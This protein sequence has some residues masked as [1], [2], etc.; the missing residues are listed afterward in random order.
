MAARG[1][2]GAGVV[3]C[4]I[5]C[6]LSPSLKAHISHLRLVH[7]DDDRFSLTCGI[8]ECDKQ[9]TSFSGYNSHVYRVHRS[10]L[11][12]NTI[13]TADQ[14]SHSE[15]NLIQYDDLADDDFSFPNEPSENDGGIQH[16]VWRLLG[17]D[18]G[19]RRTEAATFLL[20]LKEVCHVSE[21]TV[22]EVISG[23]QH[24]STHSLRF[25][26]ASVREA[27]GKAGICFSDVNGL[28]EAFS[29]IPNLFESLE[30][31]YKQEKYFKEH[32]NFLVSSLMIINFTK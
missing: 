15:D 7:S 9:F 6:I 29:S 18:E 17:V 20:K 12:L 5:C 32:F 2:D 13:N 22:D 16:D 14:E 25:V 1:V 21:R 19:L 30:T 26:K 28:E 24:L 31:T 8:Q 27:L 23:Y 11:G 10:S 4:Q 3:S